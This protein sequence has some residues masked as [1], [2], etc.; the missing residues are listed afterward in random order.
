MRPINK[1]QCEVCLN[2]EHN[3][4]HKAREMMFGLREEF[5]YLECT[6]CGC[7][8]LIDVPH[9]MSKYYPS[10]YYSFGDAGT[11]RFSLLRKFLRRQKHSY[12]LYGKN[13]LGRVLAERAG[14]PSHY[15]WLKGGHVDFD[16]HILD[17][18]CGAGGFL[19]SLG[20][21]GFTNLTGAD[22]FIEND[23][24]YK[25]GVTIWKKTLSQVDQHFDFVMMNHAFE[26]MAEPLTVLR[27]VQRVLK[28]G[29][30]AMIR[31]PIASSYAWRTYGVNWVQLDPPR[32]LF[33]HTMKS[34]SFLAKKAGLEVKDVF[35]DSGTLQFTGSERYLKNISLRD[36]SGNTLFSED[37][38]A[39]FHKQADKLNQ[40]KQGDQAGFYL[41]KQ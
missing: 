14:I 4:I 13:L 17:V 24:F 31:I 30:Y 8:Q 33:L 10:D 37:E 23:I 5:N 35:Y 1:M 19:N 41:Y 22:P 36:D 15:S 40:E 2:S 39:D 29:R 18:G 28:P 21:D 34:M 11:E 20:A 16:S 27:D 6:Q 9:D 38:L 32:H 12:C 3:S 25:N 26:H 7:I